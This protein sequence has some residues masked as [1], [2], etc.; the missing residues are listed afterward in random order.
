IDVDQVNSGERIQL[1]C[2]FLHMCSGYYNYKAGYTPDF[3]GMDDFEG[4]I[5]HPQ[6]W[7]D[8]IETEGKRIIVIGSGATAVTLVPELAKAA[9]H[10]TMLQ[11][12]PTYVVAL[13]DEDALANGLRARLPAK[14]AYAITRWKNVLGGMFI[15]WLSR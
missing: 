12:S 8:D 15:F 4:R 2:N 13:P 3:D 1:T 5:V 14:V 7:T 9:E 10:V 6:H 11:R